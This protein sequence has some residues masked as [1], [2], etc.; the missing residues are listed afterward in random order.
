VTSIKEPRPAPSNQKA[1]AA[2]VRNAAR[3]Y[4]LPEGRLRRQLGVAVVVEMLGRV[5]GENGRQLFLIKGGSSIELR[6]GVASS[7]TTNDLDTVFRGDFSRMYDLARDA[8]AEGW[9]GFSAVVTP[10]EAINA[11]GLRAKP[12]RFEVKLSFLGQP[13][14][15]VP[16][17]VSAAES[18]S[19]E[20]PESV[21][22][23]LFAHVGLPT[24]GLPQTNAVA[25][26]TLD[27]QIAQKLHAC[28]AEDPRGRA[29][30]RAHDL[31][32]VLLLWGLVPKQE[33]PSVRRACLD[34]FTN[35]ALHPWPPQ[36][37]PPA[38]WERLYEAAYDTVL[39]PGRRPQTV[40]EAAAAVR[41]IVSV[42]DR[43]E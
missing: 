12:Q 1:L 21:T 5:R 8:L 3:T 30:D 19:A 28:T 13:W 16:V 31:I 35:R 43:A 9:N 25:C 2:R 11:P 34:I 15:T 29:N 40:S 7:R 26:L 27:Y 32:D 42:I 39:E 22:P 17:E 41:D 23:L 36:L 38:H 6:L 14:R 33:H 37:L 24:L 4:D 20:H 10:Q 18:R